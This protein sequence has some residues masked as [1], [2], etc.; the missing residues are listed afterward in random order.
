MS[1]ATK[2]A[3]RI[4]AIQGKVSGVSLNVREIGN[5]LAEIE[6]KNLGDAWPDSRVIDV[7]NGH[8]PDNVGSEY[9][10]EMYLASL[11][12]KTG[13]GDSTEGDSTEVA[14]L[15]LQL[16]SNDQQIAGLSAEVNRLREENA[17]LKA[18]AQPTGEVPEGPQGPGLRV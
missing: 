5:A 14:N 1:N 4:A 15:K 8:I 16:Q 12:R 17:A 10:R 3:D 13:T 11:I 18:A 7:L 9:P 6:K 2:Y